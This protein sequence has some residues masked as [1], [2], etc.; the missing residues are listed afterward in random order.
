[1]VEDFHGDGAHEEFI[2]ALM[3]LCCP[4]AAELC[5]Q[6]VTVGEQSGRAGAAGAAQ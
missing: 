1:M 5:L 2:P 4:D 3:H 6:P